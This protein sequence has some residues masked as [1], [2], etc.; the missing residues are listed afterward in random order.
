MMNP[1]SNRNLFIKEHIPEDVSIVDFG[2]GNKEI[3]NF[4]KPK[5][6]LGIDIIDSA[7][8]K[9]DLN[10]NF[11]LD[12]KYD[13]GLLLG[14]LEYLKDPDFTLKNIKKFADRF[15]IVSLPV[16][17]KNEWTQAFTEDSINILLKQHFSNLMHF[18]YGRYILSVG[19]SK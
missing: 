12:E 3:L 14:V 8:L 9:I 11:V 2:C 18:K 16:K 6:Y 17:K 7:D 13:L 19:D 5:K 1:W 10:N 4:C 15:I